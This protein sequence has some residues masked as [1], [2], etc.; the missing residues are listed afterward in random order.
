MVI[1]VIGMAGN[2][3][4]GMNMGMGGMMAPN[5]GM[6]NNNMGGGMN[7]NMNMGGGNMA[8]NNMGGNMGGG[9]NMGQPQVMLVG[10]DQYGQP[11]YQQVPSNAFGGNPAAGGGGRGGPSAFG[12]QPGAGFPNGAGAFGGGGYPQPGGP[13]AG[14]AFG[15][16]PVANNGMYGNGPTVY[17]G[18]TGAFP[19]GSPTFG[20]TNTN[21]FGVPSNVN[22]NP[23][24]YYHP[25]L[26]SLPH[27]CATHHLCFVD[28][29]Q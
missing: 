9:M 6:P 3:M 12:G 8:G 5:M 11:I 4:G 23:S 22:A 29:M 10:Y 2:N 7:M 17:G 25:I 16:A 21:A 26:S 27:S 19:S 28:I 1:Y 24:V 14:G 20:P 18:A 13:A 15:N